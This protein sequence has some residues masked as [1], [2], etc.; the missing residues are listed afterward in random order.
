[1][2]YSIFTSFFVF[3]VL[4]YLWR[5][6]KG[7]PDSKILRAS[8]NSLVLYIFLPLLTFS[9]IYAAPLHYDSWKIPFIAALVTLGCI[10]LSLTIYRLIKRI[11][12]DLL[13]DKS[14]GALIL[15]ASWCNATYLG[16]PIVTGILGIQYGSIPLIYDLLALTPLLWII[17]AMIAGY[18]SDDTSSFKQRYISGI[19]KILALPPLYALALAVLCKILHIEIHPMILDT[20]SLAGKAVPPLMMISV[21]MALYI[22][23]LNSILLI[24]P[25][26]IIRLAIGPLIAYILINVLQIHE[27]ISKAI[28]LES[29]MPTMVL[30]LVIA[31]EY[32]LDTNILAQLIALSTLLSIISLSLI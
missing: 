30:T 17:G 6:I 27:P 12:P 14:I 24:L 13:S 28:M 10:G 26:A 8:I 1:M 11:W 22:P 31:Q 29:G 20:C 23:K 32:A 25:A 2:M 19:K 7:V 3:I 5:Y 18:Y 16:Y 4:G 15:G 21:G 9:V